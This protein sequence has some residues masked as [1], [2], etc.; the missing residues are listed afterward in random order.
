MAPINLDFYTQFFTYL[1]NYKLVFI[2]W[3]EQPRK[4]KIKNKQNTNP[5]QN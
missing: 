5:P 1:A 3:S 4:M 2:N